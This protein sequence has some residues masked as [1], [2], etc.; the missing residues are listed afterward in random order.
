MYNFMEQKFI[1]SSNSEQQGTIL[2]NYVNFGYDEE[3]IQ[4]VRMSNDWA[5][6]GEIIVSI[7]F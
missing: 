1:I 5:G 3:K 2:E 6:E 4:R 7:F